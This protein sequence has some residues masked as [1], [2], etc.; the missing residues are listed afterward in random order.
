MRSILKNLNAHF[1]ARKL[2]CFLHNTQLIQH[3]WKYG[4]N[5]NFI[6]T[7]RPRTDD[8][9]W[10]NFLILNPAAISYLG[11]S[12]RKIYSPGKPVS[13]ETK[14]CK[15]SLPNIY[16]NQIKMAP[17]SFQLR[18]F[19]CEMK[20]IIGCVFTDARTSLKIWI[21]AISK[22]KNGSVFKIVSNRNQFLVSY[23]RGESV[24]NKELLNMKILMIGYVKISNIGNWKSFEPWWSKA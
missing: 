14:K 21:F 4:E 5:F 12:V 24:T 22:F 1:L 16:Q 6:L 17:I 10:T 11:V 20:R 9:L 13:D 8:Q 18:D 19:C 23:R 2:F 15:P 7:H 3:S